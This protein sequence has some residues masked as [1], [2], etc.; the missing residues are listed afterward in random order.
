MA[1]QVFFSFHY[2]NDIFRV[3]TI[4]HHWLT[5]ADRSEA[6]YWDHSLWEST[7]LRGKQALRDL[8]ESGLKGSTVTAV[9]IGSQTAGREWVNYE[10]Q[11]SHELGKGMFGIYINQIKCAGTSSVDPR[12]RNPFSD[13]YTSDSVWTRQSLAS[14]YPVYDWVANDGYNNFGSWVENAARQSGR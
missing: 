10:I 6:G 11:R 14:I 2:Q 3:N 8:I 4:R 13:H 7:K 12:G 9:L 5:K 1:R